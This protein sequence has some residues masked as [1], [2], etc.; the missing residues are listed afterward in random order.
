LWDNIASLYLKDNVYLWYLD[1]EE[2][3]PDHVING[4]KELLKQA[5]D[6]LL[7]PYVGVLKC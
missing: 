3:Y 4:V 2:V 5:G 6:G 1:N 7:M